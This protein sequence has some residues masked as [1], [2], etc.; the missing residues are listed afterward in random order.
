MDLIVVP[1][2]VPELERRRSLVRKHLE[3]SSQ[4]VDVLLE[5]GRQLKEDDTE[6]I[7]Q[8]FQSRQQ[9]LGRLASLGL[10]AR[11]VGDAA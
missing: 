7:A 4:A 1:T 9:I 11:E 3:E 8:R 2:L 6:P 5:I 10:H